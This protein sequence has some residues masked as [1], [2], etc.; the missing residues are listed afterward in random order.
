[1]TAALFSAVAFLA[2]GLGYADD[3]EQAEARLDALLA[4]YRTYVLAED[5]VAAT[6]A[7]VASGNDRLPGVAP[8]DL[9]RRLLAERRFLARVR[10][11][12]RKSLSDNG[13]LNAELFEWV[14]NDSLGSYDLELDRN[15]ITRSVPRGAM[16]FGA[17]L[18]AHYDES[19]WSN[20]TTYDPGRWS[21]SF[22]PEPYAFLPFGQG[23]R[24][25]LVDMVA[26]HQMRAMAAT[27]L[28]RHFMTPVSPAYEYEANVIQL[29]P[30]GPMKVS[31]SRS[32]PAR[33][34]QRMPLRGNVATDLVRSLS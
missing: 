12:D 29:K 16:A 4:E 6:L 14:L 5:P 1:M 9:E 28:Q 22:K 30:V 21:G 3:T 13:R 34:K 33:P 7:G 18:D 31:L 11:H 32:A 8:E 19:S 27:L 25:C 24:R 15:G 23:S 26:L 17:V 20:A 10:D 2:S